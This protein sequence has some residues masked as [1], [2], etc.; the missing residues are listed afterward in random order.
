MKKMSK[1][2]RKYLKNEL[3]KYVKTKQ[4]VEK[5]IINHAYFEKKEYEKNKKVH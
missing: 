3:M 2:V 4:D 5:K 1:E